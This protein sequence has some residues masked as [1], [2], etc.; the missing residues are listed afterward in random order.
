MNGHGLPS[1]KYVKDT[2]TVAQEQ[3]ARA[4]AEQQ[5]QINAASA[6]AG[7]QAVANQG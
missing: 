2:Q 7:A 6:Q 5:Q 1:G 3:Q 4:A